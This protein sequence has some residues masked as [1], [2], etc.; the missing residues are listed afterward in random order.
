MLQYL[1][2]HTWPD[3]SFAVAQC[4]RYTHNPKRQHEHA[5]ERIGLY[6]KRTLDQGLILRPD[7]ERPLDINCYVDADFAD[8]FGYEQPHDLSCEEPDRLRHLC[9]QLS[10]HMVQPPSTSY[11]NINHQG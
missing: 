8:L 5:L 3:I 6:L 10:G 2:N 11:C 4:A 1:A 7:L 9:G